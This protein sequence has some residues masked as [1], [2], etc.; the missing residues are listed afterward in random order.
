MVETRPWHCHLELPLK[1]VCPLAQ[2]QYGESGQKQLSH[3]EKKVSWGGGR[4]LAWLSL[5]SPLCCLGGEKDLLLFVLILKET[6]QFWP[7][8]RSHPLR[9]LSVAPCPGGVWHG[10]SSRSAVPLSHST[11][12]SRDMKFSVPGAPHPVFDPKSSTPKIP[13]PVEQG[14]PGPGREV[15]I[16]RCCFPGPWPERMAQDTRQPVQALCTHFGVGR[17]MGVRF[18]VNL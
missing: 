14:P 10:V 2:W 9:R 18:V 5:S 15:L 3:Y 1:L 4:A 6:G 13:N 11:L 8:A 12:H 16:P 7:T 17:S